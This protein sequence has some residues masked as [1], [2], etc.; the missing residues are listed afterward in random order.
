[1][2]LA[3]PALDAEEIEEFLGR[4]DFFAKFSAAQRARV[5]LV[6]RLVRFPAGKQVY[7][8]G[9][10]AFTSYVLVEGRILFSLSV[11][12]RQASA[13]QV[14]GHGDVFGWA[15]LVEPGQPRN[16]TAMAMAPC[17]ALAIDGTALIAMADGDH[18]LGYVLMRALNKIIT[19]TLTA[20]AA[21]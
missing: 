14:I 11:G 18:S 20:F 3:T 12:Q 7:Q 4:V 16:G 15:A 9:D 2:E 13:G 6:S 19:G 10:P 21:G 5:A 17:T 8:I 1:M